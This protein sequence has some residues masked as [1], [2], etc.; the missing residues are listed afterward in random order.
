[1]YSI[2][3]YIKYDDV[4]EPVNS[5]NVITKTGIPTSVQDHAWKITALIVAAYEG[6]V[7]IV[8]MLLQ[9]GKIHVDQ[10]DSEVCMLFVFM[11]VRYIYIYIY[12]YVLLHSIYIY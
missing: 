12:M 3:Y 10:K 4:M 8:Q 6:H 2:Y 5:D 11:Y 1:M 7:N 9:S